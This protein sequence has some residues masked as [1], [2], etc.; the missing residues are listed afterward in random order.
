M[1]QDHCLT[2]LDRS[3]FF[4]NCK[5]DAAHARDLQGSTNITVELQSKRYWDQEVRSLDPALRN[6]TEAN[7]C[8]GD[9]SA[10][11]AKLLRLAIEIC[12]RTGEWLI[13]FRPETVSVS[14][15]LA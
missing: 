1:S 13:V 12:V 14:E 11:I 2:A 8:A 15:T 10:L 5:L 9:L 6:L 4:S 7:T 3:V